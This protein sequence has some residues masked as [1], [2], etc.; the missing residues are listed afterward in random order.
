VADKIRR[1]LFDLAASDEDTDLRETSHHD[2]VQLYIPEISGVFAST[3]VEFSL[4][5]SYAS[6]VTAK[7]VNL[8]EY[9]CGTSAES[10]LTITT[11]G[12][13]EMPYAGGV[14]WL[15]ISFNTAVTQATTIAMMTPKTTF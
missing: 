12:I 11:G 2:S 10:K 15:K 6:D 7:T 9:A 1:I 5:G 13:Y 4:Q 8:Y 14:Q 3:T